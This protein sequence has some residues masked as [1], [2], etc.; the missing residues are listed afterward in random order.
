MAA[1]DLTDWRQAHLNK[2]ES[3][4]LAESVA[5]TK[6]VGITRVLFTLT[7]QT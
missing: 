5:E 6:H 2:T 7:W 3:G 1:V 4:R